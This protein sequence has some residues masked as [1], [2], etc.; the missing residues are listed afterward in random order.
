MVSSRKSS[1]TLVVLI[2]GKSIRIDSL[3][4]EEEPAAR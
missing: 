2:S 1:I 4:S 3:F